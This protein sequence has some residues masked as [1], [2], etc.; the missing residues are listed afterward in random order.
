MCLTNVSASLIFWNTFILFV[1]N[2]NAMI[3]NEYISDLIVISLLLIT[4][5]DVE[6]IKSIGC[7]VYDVIFGVIV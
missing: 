2:C 3:P 5:G 7:S 6:T 1:N 4:S